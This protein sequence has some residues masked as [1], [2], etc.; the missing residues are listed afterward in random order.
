MKIIIFCI[1]SFLAFLTDKADGNDT[2]LLSIPSTCVLK[3]LV[4]TSYE[5]QVY[6]VLHVASPRVN[7]A[8]HSI[9]SHVACKYTCIKNT[10]ALVL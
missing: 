1:Q 7:E 2:L 9:I 10:A 8:K 4:T 6:Y 5:S 3:T